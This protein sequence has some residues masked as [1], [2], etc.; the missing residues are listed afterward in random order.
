[1]NS[2]NYPTTHYT[3]CQVH[4]RVLKRIRSSGRNNILDLSVSS[5]SPSGRTARGNS[6]ASPAALSVAAASG[7]DG[8]VGQRGEEDPLEEL[9]RRRAELHAQHFHEQLQQ[10]QHGDR[11]ELGA[12]IGRSGTNHADEGVLR[13]PP[14]HWHWHWGLTNLL[15]AGGTNNNNN[16][17]AVADSVL[18]FKPWESFIFQYGTEALNIVRCLYLAAWLCTYTV[19]AF[20]EWFSF[21]WALLYIL[22]IPIPVRLC[23]FGGGLW[24]LSSSIWDTHLLHQ[25]FQS[26]SF[27]NRT[28]QMYKYR[29]S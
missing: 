29:L 18:G 6:H 16:N 8:S 13:H 12:T 2:P 17:N 22:V 1:M 19:P 14:R 21:G 7:G 15:A 9:R 24:P 26:Q 3:V 23:A 27:P 4:A 20:W 11:E 5:T 28:H 10:Q 25:L